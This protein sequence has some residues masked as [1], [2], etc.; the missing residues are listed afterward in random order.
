MIIISSSIL[1]IDYS[2]YYIA[3]GSTQTHKVI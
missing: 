1:D 3:L 2:L